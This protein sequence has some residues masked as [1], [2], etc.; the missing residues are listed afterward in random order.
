MANTATRLITLIM[1]LQ[2]QPNQKALEL[3]Q[4]LGTSVRS[5]HRYIAMLDEMGI[6]VYSERG[7]HGGFS[8]V[9]GYKMPPLVLTPEEAVAVHLGTSLVGEMWGKL[10]QDAAQGALAK[11]DNLLPDEQ[12][13]EVAWARRSLVA[14]G[15]HRANL[16]SFAPHLE[17]LRRAVREQRRVLMVYRSQGQPEPRPRELDPYALVL[18]WGWWYVFGHCHLRNAIRS[19]RV[20]RVVELTLLDKTFQT[21]VDFNIQA[22]LALD[23]QH[24][25][26]VQ[27]K[28]RFMAQAAHL[29]L[30]NRAMWQTCE[31]QAEGAVIV[32]VTLPDLQWAA[33]MALGYGPVVTVIEPEELRHMVSEWASAVAAQYPL[34][35]ERY[36]GTPPKWQKE[37][38]HENRTCHRRRSG[39]PAGDCRPGAVEL[40]CKSRCTNR[41][42]FAPARPCARR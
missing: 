12:R 10:Y 24:Q 31:E 37:S 27:V 3:A 2:R 4:K 5:L 33:S 7:P 15:L 22:H 18:R 29:A 8:L 32:T 1:L 13:H 14:A 25:P 39:C 17:K 21:P 30:E 26:Q 16:D 23:F 9:R 20:D 19:F 11:L 35:I 28:L 6:P 41:A 38:R 42:W 34:P 40:G 36:P